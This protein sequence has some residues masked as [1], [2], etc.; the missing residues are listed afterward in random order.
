MCVCVFRVGSYRSTDW[1][2]T[3]VKCCLCAGERGV[4][5][6]AVLLLVHYKMN[7]NLLITY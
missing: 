1:D 2:E 4:A 5:T 3:L 7:K 6:N